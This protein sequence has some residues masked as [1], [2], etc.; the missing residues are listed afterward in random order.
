MMTLMG[1]DSVNQYSANVMLGRSVAE[2][3]DN[4]EALIPSNSE[5]F[6]GVIK[7]MRQ[8]SKAAQSDDD[9]VAYEMVAE[10]LFHSLSSTEQAAIAKFAGHNGFKAVDFWKS[11]VA[12]L[13][14]TGKLSYDS[15]IGQE[16]GCKMLTLLTEL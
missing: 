4:D 6:I 1:Y 7:R 9:T 11:Q 8:I 16:V 14:K 10:S 13:V 15:E 2:F 5:E 3:G 12:R